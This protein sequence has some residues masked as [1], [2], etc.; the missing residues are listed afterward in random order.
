MLTKELFHQMLAQLPHKK[1]LPDALYVHRE[2]LDQ[3]HK[4]LAK[5]VD[6]IANA[7]KIPAEQWNIA[8]LSKT[9][10][11]L[12]L[13]W[14][15]DFFDQAYPE[16]KQSISVDLARLSHKTLHYNSD[17][18][19]PILHRKE[20]MLSPDHPRYQEYTD[21]TQEAEQS[22]LYEQSQL[23]GFRDSWL[24]LIEKKGYVL[25]DGRLFRAAMLPPE[26]QH[27]VDRHRTALV[28]KEL[29]QPL[30]LLER[31]GFISVDISL[32]D[33]GCGRGDDL[34]ELQDRGIQAQGWDPNYRP[35]NQLISADVVNLG[36]VINVI[37]DIDERLAALTGAWQLAYKLL[38]VS[39]MLANDDFI[40]RFKPYKDGVLTSRN[41]FQKYYQQAELKGFIERSLGEV[42]V[43]VAPGIFFVFKDKEAEQLFLASKQQSRRIT[44]P[45]RLPR[46]SKRIQQE[47]LL[48]EHKTLFDALWQQCLELGR[49]PDANEYPLLNELLALTGSQRTLSKWLQQFYDAEAL[50]RVA[51]Q[52][53]QDLLVYFALNLFEKRRHYQKMPL[54]IQ[55]DVRQFFGTFK[56]VESQASSLLRMIAQPALIEAACN[57]AHQTLPASQLIAGHSL[58]LHKDYLNDLP[59]LLR[60]Y[61][62]AALQLYGDLTDIDLIKIHITSGKV[63][64]MG[65][66]DFDKP[67]PMLRERIKIKMAEQKVDFFDYVDE[68]ERPPLLDKAD[69]VTK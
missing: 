1:E 26:E 11:H 54:R 25:L 57:G 28:R 21:I 69:F 63:S 31:H 41:T 12:S 45:D 56:S 46:V 35:D 10:F 8:K 67:V 65:Y 22:G 27:K 6:A 42:P 43:A 59:A 66:D 14:Y 32:F 40:A 15:P 2:T 13:L 62:G 9:Q 20:L 52:R 39:A 19:P 4:Q 17:E 37:E 5:V 49:L 3:S 55:H 34:T 16:L 29:S 48:T 44:R 47:A 18:N 24:R 50:V 61:V 23:I 53:E 68:W 33:Y 64:L 58:I 7:L 38:A 51:H 60:V 36:Y 30:K